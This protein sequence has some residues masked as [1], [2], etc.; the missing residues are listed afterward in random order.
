MNNNLTLLYVEDNDILREKTALI[1]ERYF[2]KVISTDN[3]VQALKYFIRNKIDV[4]ILDIAISGLDGLRVAKE[5]RDS[6]KNIEII[7]LTQS[8][9]KDKLIDAINIHI[10]SYLTKPASKELLHTTLTYLIEKIHAK[11]MLSLHGTY[12]FNIQSCKLH[13]AS[14]SIKLSKNETKLLKF[15]CENKES[16]HP[17]CAISN[18]IFSVQGEADTLCNNVV[19][20][21]SR[22][23]KKMLT[24]YNK[25]FF[26]IDNVYGLG[27]KIA[28]VSENSSPPQS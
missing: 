18:A 1:F 16:Y 15:L 9:D 8:S 10:H 19:Q 27:Y 13:Y 3:G 5:M 7:F 22:F 17:S 25:E 12:D 11:H 6:D 20:L 4:V 2:H 24:G 23:K 21:I 14:E 26:F 28:Y